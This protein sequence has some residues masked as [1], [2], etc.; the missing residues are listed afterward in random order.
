MSLIHSSHTLFG[1][2]ALSPQSFRKTIL[3]LFLKLSSHQ[4]L[5]LKCSPCPTSL[6]KS[7]ALL[8]IICPLIG[9]SL[10]STLRK[11]FLDAFVPYP[12]K[13]IFYFLLLRN[14]S[15]TASR[16][17]MIVERVLAGAPNLTATSLFLIMDFRPRMLGFSSFRQWT[18]H[19]IFFLL[20]PYQMPSKSNS[21]I[22]KKR[23]AFAKHPP[24]KKV[25]KTK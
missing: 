20:L 14:L 24:P 11:P 2:D 22:F 16:F 19:S 15:S 13:Y 5:P 23:L 9:D 18:E 8:C 6:E 1:T 10:V 12:E 3:R 25:N 4:L 17:L 21:T 7:S